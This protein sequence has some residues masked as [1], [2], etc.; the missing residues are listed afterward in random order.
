MKQIRNNY[1]S[2]LTTKI[3]NKANML[4]IIKRIK[5]TNTNMNNKSI[6]KDFL[7]INSEINGTDDESNSGDSEKSLNHGI[8]L[9]LEEHLYRMRRA[10]ETIRD[11]KSK[12]NTSKFCKNIIMQK[13]LINKNRQ[14]SST[15]LKSVSN[16]LK[17]ILINTKRK[18]TPIKPKPKIIKEISATLRLK[19]PKSVEFNGHYM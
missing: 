2:F 8:K 12:F 4:P 11:I 18:L 15:R 1:E 6:D 3:L 16:C 5:N 13:C 9:V 14:R 17:R 10:K 7:N 19:L